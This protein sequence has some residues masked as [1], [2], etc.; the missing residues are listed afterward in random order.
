M[1]VVILARFE[2][3]PDDIETV[4]NAGREIV[5][6]TKGGRGCLHYNLAIDSGNSSV[7]HI[8]E[9]WVDETHLEKHLALPNVQKFI[10]LIAASRVIDRK[11][12]KFDI[13]STCMI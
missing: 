1:E 13:A 3:H 11:I 8:A 10:A 4:I 5:E 6:W 7:L 2:I 9:R 12:F